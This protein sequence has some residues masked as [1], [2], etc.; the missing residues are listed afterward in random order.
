MVFGKYGALFLSLA[1]LLIFALTIFLLLYLDKNPIHS[2]SGKYVSGWIVLGIFIF[3]ALILLIVFIS[4]ASK[5]G[6]L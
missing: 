4:L 6:A 5:Y 1:C 2:P 3:V